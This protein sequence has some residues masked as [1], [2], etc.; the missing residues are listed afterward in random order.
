MPQPVRKYCHWE[1]NGLGNRPQHATALGIIIGISGRLEGALG[2]LLAMFSRGSATITIPMFH[3]VAS[4][5]AQRAMLLAAAQ[6]AL[7][8]T[9]YQAFCDLMDDF[10]PRYSERSRLVH[11]LWGY[12]NDHPD[13]ALW[14]RAADAAST[15]AKLSAAAD[16]TQATQIAN[17]EPLSLKCMLY[18]VQDLRD[19]AI[20]LD[21]YTMQVF[22]FISELMRA[23]PALA[24]LTSASTDAPPMSAEPPLD[25]P[26]PPQ[27]DPS[28]EPPAN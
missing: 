23:H 28:K 22:A 1:L 27:T 18:S 10:R 4:T 14:C 13:K 20:R 12:S 25:L 2:W 6:Q 24:A 21:N 26:P 19:V 15:I 5:D 8:P 11:N 17:A 7:G 9:E 16:Q 3:A